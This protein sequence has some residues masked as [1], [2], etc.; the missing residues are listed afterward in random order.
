MRGMRRGV[1]SDQVKGILRRLREEV[2]GIAVRTT[3]IVGFPGET[4]ADQHELRSFVAEYQFERMGVF[5]YSHEEG[6]AAFERTD[7]V[8]SALAEERR[9]ELMSLQK[10]I[11][12]ARNEALI[13]RVMTVLID[14]HDGS[15]SGDVLLAR[16]TADAPEVDSLVRVLGS[17]LAAGDLCE[18]EITGVDEYDLVARPERREPPSVSIS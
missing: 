2:P 3:F 8:P 18:V 1:S 15:A 11:H 4:E 17:G 16:T 13:G 5:T 9:A 12:V 10:T 6:T 14:G 7:L